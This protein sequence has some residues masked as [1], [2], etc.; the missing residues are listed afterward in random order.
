[1]CWNGS[2]QFFVVFW[3]FLI[4]FKVCLYCGEVGVSNFFCKGQV[5]VCC[6]FF[7]FKMCV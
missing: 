5:D 2:E 7:D 4:R 6:V 3:F 1:L